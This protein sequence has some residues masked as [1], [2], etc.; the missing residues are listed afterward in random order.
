MRPD[1][2]RTGRSRRPGDAR[3]RQSDGRGTDSPAGSDVSGPPRLYTPTEAAAV[4]TVRESWLRRQ[5]GQRRIPCTFLGRHLRFSDLDLRA[6]VAAGSRPA[7]TSRRHNT[8]S[9]Q[10]TRSIKK[11]VSD[12][13]W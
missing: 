10:T 2:G 12:Q 13:N 1:P 4:L 11:T 8:R 3:Q 7:Q 9:R 6:I 5:A